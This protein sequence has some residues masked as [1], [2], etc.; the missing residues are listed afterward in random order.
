MTID[1]QVAYLMQGADYGDEQVKKAMAEELKDRLLEAEK[2]KRPLKVY[3]GY[4]P[5]APDLH[6]G[7][8]CHNA[9]IRP[10][11]GIGP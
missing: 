5:T 11:P 3:C 2:E 10:V 9:E 7:T 8:Y 6:L 4:D 1:E